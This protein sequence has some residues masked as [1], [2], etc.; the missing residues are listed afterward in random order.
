[1]AAVS[2]WAWEEGGHETGPGMGKTS[3]VLPNPYPRTPEAGT[4]DRARYYQPRPHSSH[5]LGAGTYTSSALSKSA[6]RAWAESLLLEGFTED[7]EGRLRTLEAPLPT[8][9]LYLC[10]SFGLLADSSCE[11]GIH[12]GRQRGDILRGQF[13]GPP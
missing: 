9:C 3:A 8:H 11:L 1:M 13:W 6:G 5:L 4:P 7:M 12:L 2:W 10:S